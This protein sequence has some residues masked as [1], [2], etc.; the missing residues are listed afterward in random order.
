MY[1]FF[2][3]TFIFFKHKINQNFYI[4]AC[5]LETCAWA[6]WVRN[7]EIAIKVTN[8]DQGQTE[9]LVQQPWRTL[10][11]LFA[12]YIRGHWSPHHKT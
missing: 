11:I 6:C 5:D 9:L 10:D 3:V 8:Y 4:L 1:N 2:T 12:C 7:K